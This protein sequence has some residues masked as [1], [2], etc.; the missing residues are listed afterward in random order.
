MMLTSFTEIQRLENL[1][2]FLKLISQCHLKCKIHKWFQFL[3][4][5]EFLP[6]IGWILL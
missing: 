6:F 3:K 4:C 2:E 1:I 5:T